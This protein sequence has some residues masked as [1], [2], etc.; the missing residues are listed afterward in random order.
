[1]ADLAFR[2]Q[3]GNTFR[4]PVSATTAR[5]DYR[6]LLAGAGANVRS[7]RLNVTGAADVRVEFGDSGVNAVVPALSTVNTGVI[8]SG[9]RGTVKYRV[10]IPE[11]ITIP[12]GA[13]YLAVICDTGTSEVEI[14]FGEGA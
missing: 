1:M 8:T 3:L 4:I 12:E 9:A 6:S 14:T 5:L 10:G 13:G 11:A 2:P 7:C